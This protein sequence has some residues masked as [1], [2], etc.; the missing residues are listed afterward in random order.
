LKRVLICSLLLA[1]T[2]FASVP[3]T[4]GKGSG[5]SA[6]QLSQ[7][8]KSGLTVALPTYVPKGFTLQSM[9]IVKNKQ[10][11]LRDFSLTYKRGKSK[12]Y[13]L[14]QMASDGLGDPI[15]QDEN[16]ESVEPQGYV[17]AKSPLLGE[18]AIDYYKKKPFKR[19]QCT[20]YEMPGKSWPRYVM[21]V[22]EGL[23]AS[24][25]RKIIESLRV[26]K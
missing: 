10:P 16:D 19:F 8:R 1:A 25:G 5:L 21:V 7:A 11:E 4:N 13:I 23:D 3:T 15:M 6:A 24:E 20:W 2:A 22:G 14:I 26:L 12:D 17:K 9:E 18:V